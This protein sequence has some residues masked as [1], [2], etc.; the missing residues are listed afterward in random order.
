MST[1]KTIE[2]RCFEDL[3]GMSGGYVLDFTNNSFAELFRESVGKDIYADKYSFN[4]DSKAKRLRAFWEVEQVSV[5][6]KILAEMLEIWRFQNPKG[7]SSDNDLKYEKCNEII[8]RLLGNIKGEDQEKHF[9]SKDYGDLSFG[10]V[11]IDANLKPVLE[12][13]LT[14]AKSCLKCN[15]PLS[16][17]FMCGSML[18]GLLLGTALKQPQL[19]NQSKCSPKD[20]NGKVRPFPEWSLAQFIDVAFDLGI[21]KLDVKKFSHA[22]RDFRNYIHPYQQMASDFHP[23]QHTAEICMQVLKAAIASLNGERK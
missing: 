10:K 20:E 9:L 5:V 3:F 22:L 4:G 18:E 17:I 1:L 7:I 2:K 12:G 13:R 19:F 11:P 14:E 16:V 15:S 8:A 23:D 6:G 21:I